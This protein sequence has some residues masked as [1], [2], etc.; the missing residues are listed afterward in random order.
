MAVLL[1]LAMASPAFG[2]Y[3]FGKNKI[4]Y[5]RFEWQLMKT[6]HFDVYFYPEE[7]TVAEMGAAMAE[8]SY[9]RLQQRFGHT[10][11]HR[12]PLIFY[13]SLIYFQQTNTT[14]GLLPENVRGF[15]EFVKGRVVIPYNGSVAELG[16]AVQHEL[17]HVFMTDKIR[18]VLKKHNV[19][20]M[21]MPPLW[22]T[23]GLAEHWS[24][25]WD[26]QADM[27]LKDAV[28][29]DRLHGLDRLSAATGTLLMYK[30]GQSLVRFIAQEYGEDR[31]RLILENWWRHERFDLV[32]R[33]ALGKSL[34]EVAEDW[35]YALRKRYY[36]ALAQ[37]EAV[38]RVARQLTWG[39]VSAKPAVVPAGVAGRGEA[40]VVYLSSKTGYADIYRRALA[41]EEEPKRIIQGERTDQFESF[42]LL[43]SKLSVSR[44][45]ILAFV[46]KSDDRDRIYLW[47]LQAGRLTGKLWWEELVGLSSPTW[48]PDGKRIAFTG[49]DRAGAADLYLTDAETGSL[50]RLTEDLYD[51]RDAA[52][53]PDGRRLAFSSDRTAFGAEGCHNLFTYEL[54]T[55][56]VDQLTLGRHND[57]APA[58]SPDG[59]WLAFCSDRGGAFDLHVM[60][61]GTRRHTQLTRVLTGAF[62]PAW[63][64]AESTLVFA[65]YEGGSFQIYEMDLPDI[66]VGEAGGDSLARPIGS[67]DAERIKERRVKG[68]LRY[69]KKFSLDLAQ[70]SL[71][72]DPELGTT[73]GLQVAL[74]DVLGDHHYYILLANDSQRSADFLKRLS[75]ALT[76]VDLSRKANKAWGLFHVAD[77]DFDRLEGW[78]QRRRYGG[79]VEMGYPLSKFRRMEA[80]VVLRKFERSELD[81]AEPYL[82]AVLLSG[83]AGYTHDTSL[84]GPVGPIDGRRYNVTLGY[85]TDLES[86]Q[87]RYGTALLDYRQYVRLAQRN[88]LAF[89]GLGRISSGR[90]AQYFFLGGSWTLRGYPWNSLWGH[91]V[92]LGNAEWRFPLID[93]LLVGFPFG[94]VG[95]SAVRGALYVDAARVW[96]GNADGVLGAVGCGVRVR[97]S[98]WLVVRLDLAKRTDFKQ[99][100]PRTRSDVFFGWNF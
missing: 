21:R 81:T 33:S 42:H 20:S 30:E 34:G 49:L 74:T 7:K 92:V 75:L 4:Q 26:S 88:C 28:L 3:H 99:I 78:T 29:S 71:D 93:N 96:E 61:A 48:S 59:V 19:Y 67:W 51:D 91:R 66:R 11:Q 87:V 52:W 9:G 8:N 32:V 46:S 65:G 47:D 68:T 80:S 16:H 6:D 37:Q 23:E 79:F 44:D 83:Y 25:P 43:D 100:E 10:V 62:D 45:G 90:E 72:Y 53:S 22:F 86:A 36:P 38:S 73:G 64:D 94:N 17:V 84:W 41:P 56:A 82:S 14:P 76:A 58:W 24:Q 18:H 35:E 40:E 31:I 12:I 63:A 57:Y 98:P 85:T 60:E 27:I 69:R 70:S 2:Q 50:K 77:R 54:E 89:R 95:F 39:G 15:M 13:S 1:L 55:G 97:V 5:A